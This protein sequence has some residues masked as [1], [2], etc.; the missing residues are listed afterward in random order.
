[1]SKGAILWINDLSGSINQATAPGLIKNNESRMALNISQQELGNLRHRLGTELWL[2]GDSGG[3]RVT[4]L[5]SFDK[6]DGSHYMH[7]ISEGNLYISDEPNTQFDLQSSSEF[8]SGN[9]VEFINYLGRHYAIGEGNTEYLKYFTETGGSSNV[10]GNIEGKFLGTNQAYLVVAGGSTNPRRTYWSNVASDTFSTTTDFVETT[11]IPTGIA[12]FGNQRPFL[13]FGENSYTTVNPATVYTDEVFGYGCSSHRSIANIRGSLIFLNREGFFMLSQNQAYP[14]EISRLIRNDATYNSFMNQIAGTNYSVAA[15]GVYQG[16]YYCA[17]QDLSANVEGQDIDNCVLEFDIDQR[18]FRVH[19]YTQSGLA[20][21]FATHI[22]E[23]GIKKLYAGS[24]DNRAVYELEVNNVFTDE[25]VNSATATVNSV[26]RSKN[27]EFLNMKD[28]SVDIKNVIKLHFKYYAPT[29]SI[30]VKYA[31][32]GA[33]TFT[34]FDTLPTTSGS[35]DYEWN[36]F[37]FGKECKS[38][39]LQFE[40]TGEFAIHAFGFE[41]EG[42]GNTGLR[43]L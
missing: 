25:N 36:Y 22:D 9:N 23:N 18:V 12:S 34:T 24:L 11:E 28:G 39:S 1:M 7:M 14:T 17:L 27:F 37:D 6:S 21:V 19:T 26:F 4:G 38:I 35:V 43:G 42:K 20:S 29:T 32:D 16:R 40:T 2:T 13:V 31:L 33:T 30:T 15:A 5:H 10:S 41:V 8:T 3:G